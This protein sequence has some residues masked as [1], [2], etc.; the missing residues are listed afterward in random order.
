MN[1]EGCRWWDRDHENLKT[2]NVPGNLGYCRKHYPVVSSA[3]V[4]DVVLYY[5]NWPL[6]DRNDLCGEFRERET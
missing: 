2:R 5:G 6:T 1:C 4:G 3:K